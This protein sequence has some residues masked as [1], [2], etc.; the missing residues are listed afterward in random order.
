MFQAAV[1]LVCPHA[2]RGDRF[3]NAIPATIAAPCSFRT[4]QGAARFR[5]SSSLLAFV[6][7]MA[8]GLCVSLL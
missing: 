8:F 7:G 6:A 3:A 5:F 2:L 1:L 4:E